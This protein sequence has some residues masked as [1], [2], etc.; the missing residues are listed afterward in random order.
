MWWLS[1][2]LPFSFAIYR[3]GNRREEVKELAQGEGFDAGI[4]NHYAILPPR[5]NLGDQRRSSHLGSVH[6]EHS[7][8]LGG[9]LPASTLPAPTLRLLA[10]LTSEMS[11]TDSVDP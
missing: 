5:R 2:V 6:S 9:G 10:C 8:V 4:L 7:R 1:T 3:R 11:Q